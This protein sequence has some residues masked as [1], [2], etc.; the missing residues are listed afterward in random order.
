MKRL[1]GISAGIL[2]LGGLGINNAAAVP[3]ELSLVVDAS[4][5]INDAEWALQIQ[6]YAN[7]IRSTL[8]DDGSVAV[9]IVRFTTDGTIVRGMTEINN[10]AAKEALADFFFDDVT[11]MG[12][13]QSGN[14][15][16]TCISCG[17]FLAEG[18]FTD[19]ATRAVIDVLTDGVWT[20]GIDPNGPAGNVG[21]SRWAVAHSADAVNAIGIGV[22]PN[23]AFGVDSFAL[24][25]TDFE[26]FEDVLE[27]KLLRETGQ[28]L[29]PG[30]VGLLAAGLLSLGMMARRR[31]KNVSRQIMTG[32]SLRLTAC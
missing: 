4:G 18:T 20:A 5:S 22:T 2:M 24:E 29:K 3:L 16:L 13:S 17:I 12:L 15:N 19:T 25:A 32:T 30:T 1:M 9:S 26:D 31:R 8:P 14:G 6:G 27:D 21:T 10:A 23:F 28:V 7:A 11:M